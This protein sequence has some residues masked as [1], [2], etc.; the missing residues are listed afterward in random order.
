VNDFEIAPDFQT[1][2]GLPYSLGISGSSS[3]LYLT[4]GAA[5]QGSIISTSSFNGS[6]GANRVPGFDRN[7]FQQPKTWVL[8]LRVSKKVVVR[9]R[10]SLE[11]LAEAFNLTNH[12]NVTSVGSTAYAVST[13]KV[14]DTNE[15]VPYTSVPFQSITGTNNSNF[16]Y[17]VRQ[18]QMA[19]RLKF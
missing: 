18:L 10:Y 2:S 7:A 1:Q 9:E 5:T 6:G 14:H 4:P 15:F 16:A 12:Q 13:D 8:D 17:N 11:F 19:V 3:K